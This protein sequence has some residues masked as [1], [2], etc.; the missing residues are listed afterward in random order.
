MADTLRRL[1]G[2]PR[3]RGDTVLALALLG[4]SGLLVREAG[5]LPPPF[6][7]PLGSAAAPRFV[8]AILSVLALSLLVRDLLTPLR[9]E[10]PSMD[11]VAPTPWSAVAVV[12]VPVFYLLLMQ[13]GILGFAPASSLLMIVLAWILA[14]GRPAVVLVSIPLALVLSFG[15]NALLTQFFYIDL[16]QQSFWTRGP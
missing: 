9:G 16:P 3:R 14:P 7:D 10:S 4:F 6:F 2:E 11:A 12:V 1:W 13:F 8:A 5:R 15:L